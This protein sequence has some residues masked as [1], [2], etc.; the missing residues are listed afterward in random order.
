MAAFY[1]KIVNKQDIITD[2]ELIFGQLITHAK[3]K[4]V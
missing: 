1:N 4:L 2:K 3:M